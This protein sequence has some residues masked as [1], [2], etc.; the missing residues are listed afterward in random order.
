[1]GKYIIRRLLLIVP[2]VLGVTVMVFCLIRALPGDPARL[3]AGE[4]ATP[5]VV[6]QLRHEWGLDRPLITQYLTFLS[7]ALRGNLGRSTS[8]LMPVS[9]EIGHRLKATLRLATAAILLA[10]GVG[11]VVGVCT[12]LRPNSMADNLVRLMSL[13]GVSMPVFWWGLLLILIFAVKWNVLPSHGGIGLQSLILPAITL[14]AYPTAMI[15][16]HTRTGMLEVL[17]A[18]YVRTARAKGMPERRVVYGHALR[19]TMV[20]VATVIGLQF[21]QMVGGSIL[22][23]TVFAYP[24]MGTFLINGVLSRDYPVVQGALLVFSLVVC[25]VNL[26]VD[27]LCFILD[28]RIRH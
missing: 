16:R 2:T 15:A 4:W 8:S 1:M 14:S 24:G 18:D 9:V 3:L 10:V 7:H 25:L 22:T 28:P 5:E 13:A 26:C 27:V 19:N 21:G 11:I 20:S 23:E 12:G 17:S 6:E